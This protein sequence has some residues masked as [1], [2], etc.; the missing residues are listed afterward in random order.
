LKIKGAC[1][2]NLKN[3]DIDVFKGEMT[4][5]T[6]VSG[7]GKTSLLDGVI[8]AS[9]CAGRAVNCAAITGFEKFGSL[10]YIEQPLPGKG[11]TATAGSMLG[12]LEPVAKAF[13]GSEAAKG[14]GLKSAHFLSGSRE[15]RCPECEGAGMNTVSMD[16]FS[17]AVTTCDR[18]GG[19]GF[20]DEVLQVRA[21]GLNVYE[22]L[23]LPFAQLGAFLSANHGGPSGNIQRVPELIEKTGLGHL[24]AGRALKTLSTGELQRLKL[25]AG[26]ASK[27]VGNTLFLL[28]EPTGGLHPN[29]TD[30]LIVLF[31]ELV[32]EGNTIICVTH[33]PRMTAAA[34]AVITLGPGGGGKGGRIVSC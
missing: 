19:T 10:V 6:G 3:I 1:A 4:V 17:D 25:V 32:S 11:H 5:I 34:S 21:G 24:S 12:L 20:R 16:F 26:L 14:A 7:S 9:H 13:A 18:C 22:A 33:E 2:N 30:R 8:Y 15:G 23:Q 28:D 29:D 27:P 31:D